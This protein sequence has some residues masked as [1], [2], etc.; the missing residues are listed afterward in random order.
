MPARVE[1]LAGRPEFWQSREGV[2]VCLD[3]FAAYFIKYE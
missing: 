2:G 1:G 3:T